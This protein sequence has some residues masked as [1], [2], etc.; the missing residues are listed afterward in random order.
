MSAFNNCKEV[1][2]VTLLNLLDS[3]CPLVLSLYSIE[4]KKNYS[5]HYMQS[6]LCCWVML[7]VFKRRHYNKAFLILL[8]TFN[9]LKETGC[10]LFDIFLNSLVAFDEYPV[11]NFHSILI[12]RTKV[13]DTGDKIFFKAR[14]IDACKHQLQEFKSWF[15]PPQKYSFCPGKIKALKV[16]AAKFLVEKF[17]TLKTSPDQGKMVPTTSRQRKTVSKWMPPNIFG[18]EVVTNQVL[19]LGYNDPA[20]S[21]CSKK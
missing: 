20:G 2:Y 4:F 19:P 8:T 10:P 3:Y 15:V 11:E 12:G 17:A 1:E 6:V 14:E 5:S 16:K 7:M 9:Y 21:P 13:T 18:E